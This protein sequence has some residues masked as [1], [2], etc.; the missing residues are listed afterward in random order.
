MTLSRNCAMLSIVW[1]ISPRFR[2]CET[3]PAPQRWRRGRGKDEG[4]AACARGDASR[5]PRAAGSSA[6]RP[7]SRSHSLRPQ[8][9]VRRR[10][11]E[12][13]GKRG[14]LGGVEQ[15]GITGTVMSS[16]AQ[17]CYPRRVI[18]GNQRACPARGDTDRLRRRVPRCTPTDQPDQ[19]P[20]A[21]GCGIGGS[22]IVRCQLR[23]R[24]ARHE[25]DPFAHR[26]SRHALDHRCGN[27]TSGI[28]IIPTGL[29]APTRAHGMSL[30]PNCAAD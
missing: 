15:R 25:H 19:L 13:A 23:R 1:T 20:A 21:S 12:G 27:Y 7:G 16:I 8:P 28:G 29:D 6:P 24:E 17:L 10:R 4:S 5:P 9:A 14:A 26:S 18:A 30:P 22:L 2:L 3:P 11:G